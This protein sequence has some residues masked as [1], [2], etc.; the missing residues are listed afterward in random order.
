[1]NHHEREFFICKI[2]TGKTYL[3]NGL[4]VHPF[5]SEQNVEACI[6]YNNAL[7]QAFDDQIMTEEET[8]SWMLEHG[9]WSEENE[10]RVKGLQKDLEKLKVEIYKSRNNIDLVERIRKYIRAGEK[11]LK[12]ELEVKNSYNQNTCEGIA[13][14]EKLEY[15]IENSTYKDNE[16]YDFEDIGINE[17]LF[18]WHKSLLTEKQCR[19]LARTEPWKSLWNTY[20]KSGVKLFFNKDNEDITYNQKT[21]TMWS[22]MY[23]NIQESMDCPTKEVIADDDMLD[24]WFIVQ[25]EKREQEKAENEFDNNTNEKIKNADEVFVITRNQREKDR[26]EN[27]NTLNSKMVKKQRAAALKEKGSIQQHEFTDE[28]IKQRNKQAEAFKGKFGGN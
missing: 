27:M 19:E 7:E 16:L 20:E 23:D 28:I 26:V 1:M 13:H 2:R 11:Q 14:T 3:P 12:E 6:V 25:A 24:G 21:L 22:Q 15:L 18:H 4:I 17:V 8:E 9:L 5:T 10:E